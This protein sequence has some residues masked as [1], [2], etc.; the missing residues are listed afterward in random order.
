[1]DLRLSAWPLGFCLAAL[2]VACGS[3][4][5]ADGS[6]STGGP[7][8]AGASEAGGGSE[9]RA[10]G[11]GAGSGV[12]DTSAGSGGLAAAQAGG[13]AGGASS[14]GGVVRCD[15]PS[16]VGLAADPR[17]QRTVQ[18]TSQT[19]TDSCDADGN[20][21]DYYCETKQTCTI[22]GPDPLPNCTSVNTGNVLS[23]AYDCSGHCVNGTCESRCPTFGDLMSYVAVDAATGSATLEN[24]T[25]H[26]R[27]V[28]QLSFDA[29][30]DNY[31]CKT[32]PMPG[33]KVKMLAQGL[34][35]SYCTG[36][37]FGGFGVGAEDAVLSD[38]PTCDYDCVIP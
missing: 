12:I 6:G 27:Y 30:N 22:P 15:T 34:K 32:G 20:L 37:N 29:A 3:T 35:S 4:A 14:T 19:S 23:Q 18:G 9:G 13:S 10:G 24:Q 26:R 7:G 36:G 2:S 25:D 1:M 5:A 28:C 16:A 33:A 17:V 31:D 8:T 38:P 21:V 11:S